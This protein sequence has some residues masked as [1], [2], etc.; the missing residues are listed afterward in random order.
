MRLRALFL[1]AVS[2]LLVGGCGS[3]EEPAPAPVDRK[4]ETVDKLPQLKRGY[5]EFVNTGAGVAFG[6]PPGW[7]AKEQGAVTEL[8]APDELVAA[9]ISIDR[10]DDALGLDPKTSATQTAELLPGYKKP[11]D[12]GKAKPFKHEYEGAIVEAKGVAKKSGVPQR[13]SVI[14]LERNGVA[15]VTAVI[16]ENAERNTGAESKQA[17]EAIRT[18]RTRPPN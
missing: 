14:V 3:K 7:S 12:P 16:A 13:V 18:L 17:L 8:N 11:L 15:V 6:R 10:T 2:G 1:A 9:R 4:E 5:E